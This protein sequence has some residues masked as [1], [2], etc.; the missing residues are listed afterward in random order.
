MKV[1]AKC[2]SCGGTGIYSGFAEAEGEAVI[3]LACDGTGCEEIHYE[4]FTG[5][6]KRKGITKIRKS[7]GSFIL[8]GV[9]GEGESM[10]YSEFEKAVPAPKKD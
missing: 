7:R 4:P 6:K 1:K 5:R 3:C 10:T 9:G 8:T 2:R